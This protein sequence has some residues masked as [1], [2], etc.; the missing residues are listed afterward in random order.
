MHWALANVLFV[1]DLKYN[2]LRL[3]CFDKVGYDVTFSKGRSKITKNGKLCAQGKM[4]NNLYELWSNVKIH[5]T[6]TIK[7]THDSCIRLLHKRM[8]H[9]IFKVLE[10]IIPI[11]PGINMKNCNKYLDCATCKEVKTKAC[12]TS[13]KSNRVT[14][15]KYLIC[16]LL[17]MIIP[18]LD[19]VIY[20]NVTCL[21]YTSPSPRD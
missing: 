15:K 4:R 19:S 6:I 3:S 10:K 18:D 16:L 14:N 8:S 12:R 13:K 17:L 2:L 1:P 7:P 5:P 9:A 11:S 20:S 21:L